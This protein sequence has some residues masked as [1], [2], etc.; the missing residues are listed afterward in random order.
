MAEQVAVS[1]QRALDLSIAKSKCIGGFP[2]HCYSKL[3][4]NSA[5][6]IL[7][8]GAYSTGYSKLCSLSKMNE[9]R[10]NREDSEMS[11]SKTRDNAAYTAKTFLLLQI[12]GAHV[13]LQCSVM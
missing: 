5:Q 9:S 13:W 2:F 12:Y 1:D 6:S 4:K 7:D 3:Y 8:Y 11:L 10:L